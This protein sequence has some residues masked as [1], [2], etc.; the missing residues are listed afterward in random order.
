MAKSQYHG[1]SLVGDAKSFRLSRTAKNAK[2]FKVASIGGWKGD[3]DYAVLV[4]PYFQ[5]PK[6]RS[7]IY[8]QALND[9]VA[10]FSWEYLSVLLE[11]NVVETH[12]ANIANLWNLSF[13]L[14][15]NI[16]VLDKNNSFL[17]RQDELLRTYLKLDQEN[18]S[19]Y[20]SRYK[21]SIITR[22]EDEIKYWE[23]K[24]NEIKLYSRE[25]AI[26]EL[27]ESLKL[28]EK[29]VTIKKY[30]DSLREEQGE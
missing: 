16:N 14:S 15:G 12:N 17:D 3:S 9:N 6:S 18:F 19:G 24:A 8:G 29:I 23:V 7:Q 13:L 26:K 11:N 22:G 21:A 27:L 25:R 10:L 4:C 28:S 30:I 2:D 20:F 5:Y 1:Y